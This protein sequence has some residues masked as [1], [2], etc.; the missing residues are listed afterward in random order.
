MSASY[1]VALGL[2]DYNSVR[3]SARV[4][5]EKHGS[6]TVHLKVEV[7]FGYIRIRCKEE[8]DTTVLP[9][10]VLM[11]CG[12]RANVPVRDPKYD[13]NSHVVIGKLNLG[14]REM[15]RFR[16]H[17]MADQLGWDVFPWGLAPISITLRLGRYPCY[18]TKQMLVH[19]QGTFGPMARAD[20]AL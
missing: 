6:A 9:D 8:F 17:V 4:K 14:P 20:A 16:P 15:V 5:M 12:D 13:V 3:P 19:H 18:L 11:R 7:T 1:R 2:G 10:I